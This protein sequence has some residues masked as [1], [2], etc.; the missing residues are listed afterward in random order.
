MEGHTF[1]LLVVGTKMSKA[2]YGVK[3]LQNELISIIKKDYPKEAQK[4]L[5]LMANRTLARVKKKT[6]VDEGILRR[7]WQLGDTYKNGDDYFIELFTD[8]DYGQHVEFGHKTGLKSG[9]SGT[10][11]VKGKFMLTLSIKELEN[12]MPRLVKKFYN[13]LFEELKM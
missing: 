13:K 2:T 9:N 3:E 1:K 11:F 10:A 12:E 8:E 7:S 4:L 6:P 5:F